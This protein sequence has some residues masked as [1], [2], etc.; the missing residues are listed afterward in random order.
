M[1]DAAKIEK[2]ARQ[3]G[4]FGPLIIIFYILLSQIIAPLSGTPGVLASA[5][6]FGVFKTLLC[7][8]IA[9]LISSSINFWISKK[10]GRKLVLKLVGKKMMR[11]IDDFVQASGEKILIISR[12]FG[13]ALFDVISYAAGLTEIKF[14]KYFAI[15]AVFSCVPKIV[16]AYFFKNADLTSESTLLLWISAIIVPGAIFAFF[17]KKF[18]AKN[19]GINKR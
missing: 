13:F 1:L 7:W 8:Y 3:F 14:K 9:G 19:R 11:E 16:L 6:L 17:I 12:V 10:F 15:T 2:F 5:I 18:I 4:I